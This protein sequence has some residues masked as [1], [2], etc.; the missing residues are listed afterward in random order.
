MTKNTN[1]GILMSNECGDQE[2]ISDLDS[3]IKSKSTVFFFRIKFLGL[4]F[5]KK[6]FFHHV[7]FRPLFV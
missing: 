3:N 4:L 7:M 6:Y 5:Y 2:Q 1:Q